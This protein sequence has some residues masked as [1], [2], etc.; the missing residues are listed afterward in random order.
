MVK[1]IIFDLDG[2]LLYTLKDLNE[3]VNYA[4]KVNNFKPISIEQTRL[5]IGN[6]VRKLIERA[7]NCSDLSIIEKGY[8]DFKKHYENHLL[9]N[10]I[11]YENIVELVESLKKNGIKSAICSNK[12]QLGVEKVCNPFFKN[13]IDYMIGVS[14]TIRTKPNLDMIDLALKK[15][16]I[17]NDSC[18]YVGDSETDLITAKSANIKFVAVSWGYRNVKSLIEKGAD[19]AIYNPP[20]L[21]NIIKEINKND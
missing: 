6:G 14:D 1:G 20:E 17:D 15:M 7:F 16:N 5:F 4:C 2:T 18:L 19:Y 10:T 8:S 13:K 12:Y 9:D 21:L 11:P 3:A